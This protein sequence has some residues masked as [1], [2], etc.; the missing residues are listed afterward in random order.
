MRRACTSFHQIDEQVGRSPAE[1]VA[2]PPGV[3]PCDAVEHGDAAG[4]EVARLV[5]VGRQ[6]RRDVGFVRWRQRPLRRHIGS[7]DAEFERGAIVLARNF[8]R[9][10]CVR[11]HEEGQHAQSGFCRNR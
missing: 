6:E 10:A 2:E 8:C 11:C 4:L 5:V 7:I 3:D 9:G 1:T